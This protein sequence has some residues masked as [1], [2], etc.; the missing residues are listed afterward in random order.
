MCNMPQMRVGLDMCGISRMEE[1]V[2]DTRFLN[3]FFTDEEAEYIL[4]KGTC[5]AQTLAGIFAAKEAFVKALGT[6]ISMPM[7]DVGVTH[8]QAGQPCYHLTGKA[9]ELA[10]N[11]QCTLSITHEGDMAAA[12]CIIFG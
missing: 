4:S 6:G 7:K 11:A 10:G 12:V 9:K 3:R 5:A 1:H 8:A 2:R